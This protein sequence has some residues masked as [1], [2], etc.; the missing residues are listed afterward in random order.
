MKNIFKILPLALILLVYSCSKEEYTDMQTKETSITAEIGKIETL[1]TEGCVKIETVNSDEYEFE[2]TLPAWY[3][4][5]GDKK[6]EEIF[7]SHITKIPTR[8]SYDNYVGVIQ[9]GAC[10]PWDY[11][12][13]NIDSEDDDC[14]THFFNE[15]GDEFVGYYQASITM[16]ST[17]NVRLRFCLVPKNYFKKSNYHDY[18]VLNIGGAPPTGAK[19]A[20]AYMDSEDNS[21]NSRFFTNGSIKP[22]PFYDLNPTYIS[23]SGNILMHFW[24]F[25]G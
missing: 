8:T 2:E 7:S 3:V 4:E 13:M 19:R 9:D 11:L 21:C 23:S 15:L 16:T 14:A 17:K 25:V 10:S 5:Y 6:Y 1:Y 22:N 12:Q 20:Y 18:A 24:F